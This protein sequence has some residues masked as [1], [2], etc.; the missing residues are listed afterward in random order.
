MSHILILNNKIKDIFRDIYYSNIQI[1]YN[2]PKYFN[3]FKQ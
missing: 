1:F 3:V 2:K